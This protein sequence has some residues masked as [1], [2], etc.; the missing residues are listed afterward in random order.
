MLGALSMNK[1]IVLFCLLGFT[2]FSQFLLASTTPIELGEKLFDSKKFAMQ[3]RLYQLDEAIEEIEAILLN[4][5]ENGCD[6][7]NLSQEAIPPG[8]MILGSTY[9]KNYKKLRALGIVL[10]LI[11][12]TERTIAKEGYQAVEKI[13]DEL[14]NEKRKLEWELRTIR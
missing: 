14:K 6:K 1:K 12:L 4:G 8:I 7:I 3:M 9:L 13:H 11:Y 5:K 2:T 10:P